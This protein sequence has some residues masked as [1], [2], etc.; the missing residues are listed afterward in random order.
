MNATAIIVAAGEGSRI[1]GEIGKN[2]LPIGGRTLLLRT[3][4]QFYRSKRV[5]N[6]VLVVAKKDLDRCEL[7]LRGDRQL[8]HR[9]WTLQAGGANRQ[10][11]VRRGLEKLSDDCD[12]VAIHD[13]ARPFVSPALIDRSIEEAYAREAIVVGVPVRDTIKVIAEDR[14]ILSTPERNSLS[15][16]QTPQTFQRNLIVEAHEWAHRNH[17]EGTDDAMLVEQLG[18]S[19]YLINGERTNIKITVP[20][21]LFFAEALIRE[22]R[23]G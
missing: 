9:A 4:D 10:E 11:S 17:F 16:I 23:V 7:L 18:R 1:G 5:N 13:G 22:G 6:V 19:V 12:V 2:Y 14:R 8:G 20:E 21:D 3:L 15:E